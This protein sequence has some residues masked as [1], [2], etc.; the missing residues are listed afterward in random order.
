MTRHDTPSI[1]RSSFESTLT[2]RA[3]LAAILGGALFALLPVVEDAVG[4]LL[5]V[6]PAAMTTSLPEVTSFLLLLGG[7]YG[8]FLRYT[9]GT[10]GPA[11]AGILAVAIGLLA[12]A[13]GSVAEPFTGGAR[14]PTSPDGLAILI[15]YF[16]VLG[17]GIPLGITLPRASTVTRLASVLLVAAL[18]VA[19][20]G[21]WIL[22]VT[23]GSGVS[24]EL[25]WAVLGTPLGVAFVLLGVQLVNGRPKPR[26][27][28][29]NA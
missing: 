27:R 10:A 14:T 19:L 17:G 9:D 6:A 21:S 11:T 3:G 18:P 28:S 13:A 23:V 4:S 12:L 25:S 7:L 24:T 16:A 20:V 2:R 1:R 29:S 22:E 8:V 15:G 5:P 26:N